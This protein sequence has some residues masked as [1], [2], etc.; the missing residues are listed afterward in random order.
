MNTTII[1][2]LF[3]SFIYLETSINTTKQALERRGDVKARGLL[4]RINEYNDILQKQRSLAS[5]LCHHMAAKNW[6][7]VARNIKLINA[8]SSMIRDDAREILIELQPRQL[9]NN[10]EEE[11]SC[12]QH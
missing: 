2:R 4:K 5:G 10:E 3:E 11:S 8:L 7:E 1:E 9:S 6:V 12:M